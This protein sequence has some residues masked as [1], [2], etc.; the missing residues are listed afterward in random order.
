[1]LLLYS[2]GLASA[3]I[4]K[5][6]RHW[7]NYCAGAC[8]A[9][10]AE[11]ANRNEIDRMSRTGSGNSAET[12]CSARQKWSESRGPPGEL[13]E[14]GRLGLISKVRWPRGPAYA[15]PPFG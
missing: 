7:L 11:S 8:K 12:Y 2:C 13:G 5:C 4:H 6:L 10:F 15:G 9:N 14:G 3:N 1:M